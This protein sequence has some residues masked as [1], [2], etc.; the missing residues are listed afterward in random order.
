MTKPDVRAEIQAR[1]GV[2]SQRLQIERQDVITGL[3]EAIEQARAQANPASMIAGLREIGRMLGFYEPQ[4]HA[5]EVSAAAD[6]EMGRL[7]GLSDAE[8]V[9]FMAT[10]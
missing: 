7:A 9:R 6:A 10:S 5:V 3:L 4:R 8:L 1:Q 2:D